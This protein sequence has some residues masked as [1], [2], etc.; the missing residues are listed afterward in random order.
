[1]GQLNETGLQRVVENIRNDI[2]SNIENVKSDIRN[3]KSN[4]VSANEKI[5]NHTQTLSN[6]KNIIF[7]TNLPTDDQG[8]DGDIWI[9]YEQE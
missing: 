1:M 7:S 5:E 4:L 9:K 8:V 6:F 3:I 2:S